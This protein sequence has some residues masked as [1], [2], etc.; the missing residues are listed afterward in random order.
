MK[1]IIGLGNPGKEYAR[2]RHNV[3]FHC[4]NQLAKQFSINLKQ[5][6]C[7]SQIGFGTIAGTKVLLAKPRTFVNLSGEAVK[8]LM[9]KNGITVNDVLIIYDDLDLPLGKMRLRNDGSSGGHKGM[10]SIIAALGSQNFCRIKIGIGRPAQ[11]QDTDRDEEMVVNHVL[12]DFTPKEEQVIKPAI[13]RAAEA[14]E[15]IIAEGIIAAMNKFN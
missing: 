2:N 14:A 4:V 6:Q 15:Y 13:A 7:Q 10:K 5:R 3:G 8:Q 11:E 1:L 9:R 12:S